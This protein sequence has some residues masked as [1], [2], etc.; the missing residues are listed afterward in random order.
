MRTG[1]GYDETYDDPGSDVFQ[2]EEL[3]G[4]RPFEGEPAAANVYEQIALLG[5]ARDTAPCSTTA[6]S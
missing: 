4:W 6:R 2:T 3:A 1:T 5:N